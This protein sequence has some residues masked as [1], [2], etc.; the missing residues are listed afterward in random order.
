MG[1]IFHYM[2]KM[3][4]HLVINIYINVFIYNHYMYIFGR[5]QGDIYSHKHTDHQSKHYN[6]SYNKRKLET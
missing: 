1:I 4:N 3:K 6:I 2:E 5:V